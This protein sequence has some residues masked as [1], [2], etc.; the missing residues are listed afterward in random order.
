[1][2]E[3]DDARVLYDELHVM[4]T[5]CNLLD[6]EIGSFELR[7]QMDEE[8]KICRTCIKNDI[9]TIANHIKAHKDIIDEPA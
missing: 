7:I 5:I 8:R 3:K 4:G 6:E 1:M 2:C 9:D